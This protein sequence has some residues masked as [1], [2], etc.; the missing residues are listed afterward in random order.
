[1]LRSLRDLHVAR[2]VD[3]LMQPELALRTSVSTA[4]GVLGDIARQLTEAAVED[5]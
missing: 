3:A 4:L 5:R 2:R 1:V